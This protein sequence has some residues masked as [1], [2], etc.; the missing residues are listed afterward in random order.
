MKAFY[1]QVDGFNF[2]LGAKA[3]LK[4]CGIGK[5]KPNILLMGHKS[6]WQT[7]AREELSMYFEILQLSQTAI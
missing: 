2:E 3:M 1:V 4:A 5:L 6:D 7:C